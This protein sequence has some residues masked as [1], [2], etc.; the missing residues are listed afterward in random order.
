MN[1]VSRVT[2]TLK[3]AEIRTFRRAGVYFEFKPW[4][5]RGER[6]RGGS[7]TISKTG[8]W[9][10]SRGTRARAKRRRT[11]TER[12]KERDYRRVCERERIEREVPEIMLVFLW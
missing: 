11:C 5:S 6:A 9:H 2:R 10:F 8:K 4:Q 3:W 7:I 1:S 12:K